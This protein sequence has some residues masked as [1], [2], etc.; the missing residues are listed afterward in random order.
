MFELPPD[1][2]ELL[3]PR[4]WTKNVHERG[5]HR[6]SSLSLIYPRTMPS[7]L[8]RYHTFGHD[9]FTTFSCYHRLPYLNNDHARTVNSKP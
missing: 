2:G 9:H 4:S 8:K 1:I 3:E 6:H 5:T 7:G